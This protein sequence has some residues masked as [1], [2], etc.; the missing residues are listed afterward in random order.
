MTP[1]VPVVGVGAVCV[2][3][4]RLLV[5]RRGR[6]PGEGLWALP[7]GRLEAGESLQGACA[8]ELAEETGLVGEV[9]ALRGIAER[10]GADHHFVILDFDVAVPDGP[11]ARAADDAAEVAWAGLADLAAL[12]LVPGLADWLAEHDVTG[13]LT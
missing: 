13:E 1:P 3:D 9:G 12:P 2:R 5:V 8:R 7:G 4:G 10:R 11:A 6:P